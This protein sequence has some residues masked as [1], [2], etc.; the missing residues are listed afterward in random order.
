MSLRRLLVSLLGTAALVGVSAAS[1]SAQIVGS[2]IAPPQLLPGGTVAVDVTLYCFEP[3]DFTVTA[4][5]NQ[6]RGNATFTTSGACPA[7]EPGFGLGE[8]HVHVVF[9]PTHGAFH[10]GTATG[11][12]SISGFQDVPVSVQLH[13][14][15]HH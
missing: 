13:P 8:A 12:F 14:P 5:L 3:S 6:G 2:A 7:A 9:D 10:P 1:G 4:M 11:L 15:G